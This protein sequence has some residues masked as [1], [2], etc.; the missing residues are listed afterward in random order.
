MGEWTITVKMAFAATLFLSLVAVYS[1]LVH[2]GNTTGEHYFSKIVTALNITEY[3]EHT[4][5]TTSTVVNVGIYGD[6]HNLV[7]DE[8]SAKNIMRSNMSSVIV[9]YVDVHGIVCDLPENSQEAHDTINTFFSTVGAT[10]YKFVVENELNNQI[11]LKV[12]GM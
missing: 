10:R 9:R 3:A 6:Y 4:T 8:Q 2:F 11:V 1:F 12:E 7:T 5:G